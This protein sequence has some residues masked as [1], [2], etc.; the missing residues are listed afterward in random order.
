MDDYI[1]VQLLVQEIYLS[2][3]QPGHPFVGKCNEYRPK[4]GDAL[5]LGVK[6]DIVLFADNIV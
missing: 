5:L 2:I 4:G 6:E 3:T 1:G